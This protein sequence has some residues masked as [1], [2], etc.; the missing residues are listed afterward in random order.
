MLT[1]QEIKVM[2]AALN[3]LISESIHDCKE[4]KA[5]L[6]KLQELLNTEEV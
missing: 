3:C 1:N 4:E 6:N 2:I 5:L